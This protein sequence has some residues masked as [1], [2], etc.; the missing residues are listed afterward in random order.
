M[1]GDVR[2][3]AADTRVA[4]QGFGYVPQVSL[5]EGLR[6][7]VDSRRALGAAVAGLSA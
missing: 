4:F 3:T 7:M 5:R 1:R 2:D 6:A